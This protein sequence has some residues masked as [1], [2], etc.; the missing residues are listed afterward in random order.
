MDASNEPPHKVDEGL[1]YSKIQRIVSSTLNTYV[2]VRQDMYRVRI[3]L[4]GIRYDEK[5]SYLLSQAT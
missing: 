5:M 4:L 1:S 2:H 3:D